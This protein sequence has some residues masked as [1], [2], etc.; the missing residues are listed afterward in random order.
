MEEAEAAEEKDVE[1]RTSPTS[2]PGSVQLL[3]CLIRPTDQCVHCTASHEGDQR[4]HPGHR[5]TELT[6]RS[7][8]PRVDAGTS[9]SR[10]AAAG[11]AG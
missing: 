11:H 9:S 7:C 8:I 4:G 6:R 10:G 2:P 5:N 1:V 3:D